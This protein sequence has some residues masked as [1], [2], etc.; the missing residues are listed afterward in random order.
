[1]RYSSYIVLSEYILVFVF[2]QEL[3]ILSKLSNQLAFLYYLFNVPLLFFNAC[4][5]YSD[6]FSFI[7]DLCLL[8]F[9]ISLAR[10]L[11]N[12]LIFFHEIAFGFMDFFSFVIILYVIDTCIFLSLYLFG[13]NLLFISWC[14]KRGAWIIDL[15]PFFFLSISI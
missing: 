6:V 12:L 4:R 15:R 13:F 10:D 7:S 11:S 2:F 14:L 1:M 3:V 5:I 8:F 9:S